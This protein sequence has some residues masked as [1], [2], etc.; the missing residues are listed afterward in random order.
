MINH[1][2]KVH[3]ND[4]NVSSIESHLESIQIDSRNVSYQDLPAL[5]ATKKNQLEVSRYYYVCRRL[6]LIE[7]EEVINKKSIKEMKKQS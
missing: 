5:S 7:P 3:V 1:Y 4:K 6:K 2:N